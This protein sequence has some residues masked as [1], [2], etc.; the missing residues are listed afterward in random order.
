LFIELKI[1]QAAGSI[2]FN[3]RWIK[4]APL[5]TGEGLGERERNTSPVPPDRRGA[6][7][8]S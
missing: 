4:S 2:I 8:I 5:P 3:P 1:F 6:N 7:P